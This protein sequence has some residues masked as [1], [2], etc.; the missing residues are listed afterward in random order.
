MKMIQGE[1][2]VLR[3]EAKELHKRQKSIQ[4]MARM[5]AVG[6]FF[7]FGIFLVASIAMGEITDWLFSIVIGL[8]A[9]IAIGLFW[10]L[11]DSQRK[12][13]V[14]QTKLNRAAALLN[15]VKIKYI[16]IASTVDYERSKYGVNADLGTHVDVVGDELLGILAVELVLRCAWEGDVDFLLP[17]LL[18]GEECGAGEFVGVRSDDVVACCAEFS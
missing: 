4:S 14:I 2:M 11:L 9:L 6:L 5:S 17:G 18:A 8:S 10:F 13:K 7:V 16:N 1:Q 12:V 15:K 3:A